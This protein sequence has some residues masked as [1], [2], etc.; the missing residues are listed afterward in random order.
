MVEDSETFAAI[1]DEA[2]AL[3]INE[4]ARRERLWDSKQPLDFA[5]T[6]LFVEQQVDHAKPGQ[7]R[8]AAKVVVHV[9]VGSALCAYMHRRFCAESRYRWLPM[10][11]TLI[12]AAP[13]HLCIYVVG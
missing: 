1:R 8:K 4:V 9:H 11:V 6:K 13:M 2:R 7:V 3:Q 12:T 10:R 5:A